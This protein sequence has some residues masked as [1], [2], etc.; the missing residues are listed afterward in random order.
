MKWGG[1][2][3]C[4]SDDMIAPS[5]PNKGTHNLDM[6]HSQ[7]STKTANTT[8]ERIRTQKHLF[9]KYTLRVYSRYCEA[10]W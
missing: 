5:P 9:N 10:A 4:K 6:I 8:K 3:E 1:E 7:F 2:V